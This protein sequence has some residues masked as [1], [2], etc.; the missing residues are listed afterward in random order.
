MHNILLLTPALG[1]AIGYTA[2]QHRGFSPVVGLLVGAWC[3]PLAVVLFLVDGIVR[4]HERKRCQYCCEWIKPEAAV[5]RYCG[6][7]TDPPLLHTPVPLRLVHP[8]R[9]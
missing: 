9:E 7:S 2:A 6:R 4:S 3:G 8:L 1:A 5:C